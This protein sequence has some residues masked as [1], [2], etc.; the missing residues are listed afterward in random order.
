VIRAIAIGVVLVAA[1]V[2]ACGD[3][4][5]A[6]PPPGSPSATRTPTS[7]PTPTPTPTLTPVV[8][9]LGD[10]TLRIVF[11]RPYEDRAEYSGRLWISGI[12]GSAAQPVTPEG[13]EAMFAGMAGADTLYWVE[14]PSEE[15]AVLWRQTLST[16]GREEVLRFGRRYFGHAQVSP[17]GDR[18]AYVDYDSVYLLELATGAKRLLLQ[19]NAAACDSASIGQCFLY[20]SPQWSPD[21]ELIVVQKGFYEGAIM[22]II[23]P[24]DPVEQEIGDGE[25][26]GAYIAEW[27]PDSRALCVLGQYAAPSAFY[28]ARAPDWNVTAYMKDELEP[29]TGPGAGPSSISASGCAW[30]S[31]DRLI[32]SLTAG[33]FGDPARI[34]VLD[35]NDGS[36]SAFEFASDDELY[37]RELI[38]APGQRL[39]ITQAF[40]A[41]GEFKEA[42][43]LHQVDAD[44]GAIAPILQP[45]DWAVAVVDVGE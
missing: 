8:V 33:E 17:G 2:A 10:E 14:L 37:S 36:F 18:I 39:A 6:G 29:T 40:V 7:T 20:R 45:G 26:S 43:P 19:G 13:V 3:G 34:G 23:D 1:L 4:D 9:P 31:S 35:P 15:E 22:A 27:S 25:L 12:D 21:G 28:V 44:T 11:F 24:D 32:V 38:G 5:G 41:G 16:G 30:P 42:G